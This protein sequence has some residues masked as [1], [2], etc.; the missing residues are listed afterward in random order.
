M[1]DIITTTTTSLARVGRGVISVRVSVGDSVIP[2]YRASRP[3]GNV[4]DPFHN[5]AIER[6]IEMGILSHAWPRAYSLPRGGIVGDIGNRSSSTFDPGTK[7]AMK[8]RYGLE[9][10]GVRFHIVG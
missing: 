4:C 1:S 7:L 9:A 2:E 10:P 3:H 6:W 5:V 8:A